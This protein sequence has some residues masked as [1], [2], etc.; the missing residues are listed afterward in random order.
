MVL[1]SHMYLKGSISDHLDRNV[2]SY[3]E[4][5]RIVDIF[6]TRK[7][8][9]EKY[10]YDPFKLKIVRLKTVANGKNFLTRIWKTSRVGIR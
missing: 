9:Q 2:I 7:F 1:L 10:L 3:H 8:F 4:N 5:D 6:L